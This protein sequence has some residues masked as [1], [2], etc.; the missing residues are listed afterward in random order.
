MKD[1]LINPKHV[2]YTSDLQYKLRS[3]EILFYFFKNILA[4]R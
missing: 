1:S 3:T 2:A 4:C